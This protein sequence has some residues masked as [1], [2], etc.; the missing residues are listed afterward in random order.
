MASRVT[1][2]RPL[3]HEKLSSFC[4]EFLRARAQGGGRVRDTSP[5][6]GNAEVQRFD[7]TS[8]ESV[9]MPVGSQRTRL[10][11]PLLPVERGPS[12]LTVEQNQSDYCKHNQN[13]GQQPSLIAGK[14]HLAPADDLV[15]PMNEITH[16]G[17]LWP[18]RRRRGHKR[19]SWR[20]ADQMRPRPEWLLTLGPIKQLRRL[21]NQNPVSLIDNFGEQKAHTCANAC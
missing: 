12:Q 16:F 3:N 1:D 8:L 4:A 5:R 10:S 15:P 18:G 6:V 21:L 7:L 2:K 11:P 9:P 17:L 13:A 20:N 19:S 14:H